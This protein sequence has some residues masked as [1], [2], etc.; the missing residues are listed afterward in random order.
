MRMCI[1]N[2][3][4]TTC[5]T[6]NTC[7]TGS[8]TPGG[9]TRDETCLTTSGAARPGHTSSTAATCCIS[10]CPSRAL[11]HTQSCTPTSPRTSST[12]GLSTHLHHHCHLQHPH[13]STLRS[14][15]RSRLRKGE[16]L[17]VASHIPYAMDA[18]CRGAKGASRGWATWQAPPENPG[19]QW[20]M[21]RRESHAPWPVQGCWWPPGHS[22]E[23]SC[24]A[25]PASHIRI[26]HATIHLEY[27]P[28]ALESRPNGIRINTSGTRLFT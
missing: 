4:N 27:V 6:C 19:K 24:P 1:C 7:N 23:Q 14:L 11:S 22:A 2:T 3:C 10:T 26:C 20:Q 8:A 16:L 5:N 13:L 25:Y 28:V 21:L 15:H 18:S 9:K 12:S 17:F